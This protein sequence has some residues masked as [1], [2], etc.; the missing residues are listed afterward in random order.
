MVGLY[1]RQTFLGPGA[2]ANDSMSL[3]VCRGRREEHRLAGRRWFC[4]A[5]SQMRAH[6]TRVCVRIGGGGLII[7]GRCVLSCLCLCVRFSTVN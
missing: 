1:S 6:G 3:Q 5:W 7:G 2:N 4:G